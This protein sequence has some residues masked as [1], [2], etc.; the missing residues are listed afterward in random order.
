MDD[1][2]NASFGAEHFIQSLTNA[3]GP[4]PVDAAFANLAAMLPRK[5]YRQAIDA[6]ENKMLEPFRTG[7]AED[8]R[9]SLQASMQEPGNDDENSVQEAQAVAQIFLNLS[10]IKGKEASPL[11]KS[12]VRAAARLTDAQYNSTECV[13]TPLLALIDTAAKPT[14]KPNPFR[15]KRPKR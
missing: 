7:S 5:D 12:F 1:Q 15:P 2:N 9:R 13:T 11:V 14:L 6:I 8:A 3:K 4:E 10:R